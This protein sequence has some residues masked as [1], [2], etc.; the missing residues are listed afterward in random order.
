MR[1][2][3][4]AT[5]WEV[6]APAKVN[7]FLEVQEKRPDGFH[8][9][10]TLMAPI[11]LYDTLY[12]CEAADGQTQFECLDARRHGSD[13]QPPLPLPTGAD[14]I[15]VRAVS[16]LRQ[17]T[18]V[19]RGVALRLVK[20][21]PLAA[22]LAGGSSDAAA[23]LAAVNRLWRTNLSCGELSELAAQLGSDIPFFLADGP[24]VCRGRG[25]RVE[26]LG[27]LPALHLVVAYPGFGLATAQV[28]GRCRPE[29]AARAFGPLVDAWRSQN[30]DAF[31]SLLHNTLQP[32]AAELSPNI[33]Q[34]RDRFENMDVVAHQMSGSGASWFGVCRTA[35]HARRVAARLECQGAGA[36]YALHTLN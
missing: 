10:E 32:A 22:G 29:K 15:V 4:T 24:A 5:G 23:A 9:I 36:A 11:D 20:R 7:L 28:Y 26:P 35:R 18:G 27:V 30:F 25:E 12:V 34:L 33:E 6:W 1:L 21:I 2:L 14:N 19:N 3:Q 31:G 17:A 8:E 13:T 16:L